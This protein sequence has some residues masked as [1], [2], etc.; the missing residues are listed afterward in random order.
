MKRWVLSKKLPSLKRVAAQGLNALA[1]LWNRHRERAKVANA[2]L[3]A[4]EDLWLRRRKRKQRSDVSRVPRLRTETFVRLLALFYPIRSPLW[5]ERLL[6]EALTLWP[7]SDPILPRLFWA[8][9]CSIIPY[10]KEAKA[11]VRVQLSTKSL[12]GGAQLLSSSPI[13]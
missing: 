5:L 11:I 13:T 12:F 8:H 6:G 7:S 1:A 2:V 10:S 9:A 3:D 4:N